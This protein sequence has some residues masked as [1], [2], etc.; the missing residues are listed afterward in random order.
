MD[1]FCAVGRFGH[2]NMRARARA[3]TRLQG[4]PSEHSRV[5]FRPLLRAQLVRLS[6]TSDKF[7]SAFE[8]IFIRWSS[9][10]HFLGERMTRNAILLAK[11]VAA[12]VV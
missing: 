7:P 5:T 2:T 10:S 1:K 8:S 9:T 6:L 3:P 12:L 11:Y 4:R